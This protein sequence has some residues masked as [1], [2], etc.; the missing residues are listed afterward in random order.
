DGVEDVER[1]PGPLG[2]PA[3]ALRVGGGINV[4]YDGGIHHGDRAGGVVD[5]DPAAAVAAIAGVVDDGAVG[6]PKLAAAEH[7]DAPP[8]VSVRGGARDRAAVDVQDRAVRHL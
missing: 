2:D 7:L 6:H 1:R 4:G 8:P 3:R 5:A